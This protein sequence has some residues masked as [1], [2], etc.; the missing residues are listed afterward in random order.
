M[1]DK[2]T[3]LV[4]DLFR[5]KCLSISNRFGLTELRTSEDAGYHVSVI[6]GGNLAEL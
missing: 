4:R 2:V 5:F 6:T 1:C 3:R